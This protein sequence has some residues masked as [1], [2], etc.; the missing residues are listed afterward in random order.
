M[1]R[2]C[3]SRRFDATASYAPARPSGSCAPATTFYVRAAYGAGSG[4]AIYANVNDF[5]ADLRWLALNTVSLVLVTMA[6]VA[7]VAH[8]LIYGLPWA[9]AFVLGAI[10]VAQE[11]SSNSRSPTRS[12]SASEIRSPLPIRSS[13]SGR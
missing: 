1:R 2:S 4:S 5:R 13:A 12:A 11:A 8:A 10:M 7:W 9:A 6:A 3:R